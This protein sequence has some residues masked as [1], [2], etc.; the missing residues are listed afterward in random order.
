MSVRNTDLKRTFQTDITQFIHGQTFHK[1]YNDIYTVSRA[2][3]LCSYGANTRVFLQYCLPYLLF[4]YKIWLQQNIGSTR[5]SYWDRK[6]INHS[7]WFLIVC[8]CWQRVYIAILS[9]LL[10][11]VFCFVFCFLFCFVLFCFVLFCFVLFCLIVI[12]LEIFRKNC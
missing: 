1:S 4:L 11:F 3:I 7:T 10:C 9:Y 2:I 12:F 8:T 6:R 5:H